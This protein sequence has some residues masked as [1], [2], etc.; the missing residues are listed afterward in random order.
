[1]N[2]DEEILNLKE[3]ILEDK[4]FLFDHPEEGLKEYNT[5]NYII[6]RLEEIGV[7]D[8]QKN[9]YGNGI[10]ATIYG[11]NEGKCLLFRSELDAVI[12]SNKACRH[13]CGHDAHMTIL[14][15]IAKILVNNREKLNGCVKLLFE[16]DEEGSGGADKM[17]KLGALENP[18]V[19]KVF[20]VHVWSEL[21]EGTIGINN[22]AQMASTDPFEIVIKGKGGHAAIPENCVDTINI[23]NQIG[24]KIKNMARLDENGDKKIVLGITAIH[25]GTN[26]NVIPDEASMKGICRSYNNE[27]REE[28][29]KQLV[30]E[31]NKIA[32]NLGGNVDFKFIGN[33]PAVINNKD[34]VEIIQE[35]STKI[36]QNVD[37][38]FKTMS[39][40]DFSFFL[41]QRPGAMIMVGCQTDGSIVQHSETFK[42]GIDAIFLGCQIYYEIIKKYLM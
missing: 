21:P 20:A 30:E 18:Y 8:I 27:L 23:A 9:I 33:Y 14:L 24:L 36:A 10:I 15:A 32:T 16:S 35:L 2:I 31:S 13:S 29:K 4:Q 38:E 5:S 12:C 11:K 6:K 26:N 3:Q 40:D 41:N 7:K 39:S 19:D 1:M 42:V 28:I 37:K 22:G 17:I 34:E 25:S